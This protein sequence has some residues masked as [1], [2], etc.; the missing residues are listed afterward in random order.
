MHLDFA[1]LLHQMLFGGL[2]A[3]GFGVLFNMDSRAMLWCGIGGAAALG[4]RTTGLQLGWSFE[5]ATFAAALVVGTAI[6][7]LQDR[8]GMA[9]TSLDVASCI[10]MIPGSYA[11]KAILRLFA[12]TQ[13]S[14]PENIL[15]LSLTNGVRV[16][17][18]IGAM[19]TALAI[20]AVL[21][22]ATRRG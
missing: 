20:P 19:G 18:T 6:Q 1:P 17:F 4:I 9:R 15:I 21:L 11:A 5:A 13:P 22:R 2:A 3:I 7:L 8:L 14:P 12:L 10:P 16:L